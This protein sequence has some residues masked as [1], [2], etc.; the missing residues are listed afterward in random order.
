MPFPQVV[1]L[2]VGRCFLVVVLANVQ[3][4]ASLCVLL[5][6]QFGATTGRISLVAGVVLASL[7]AGVNQDCTAMMADYAR[8][9]LIV[10]DKAGAIAALSRV[11]V[12]MILCWHCA[13][14]V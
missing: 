5:L 3:P 2:R 11:C 9:V 6:E 8:S 1:G 12:R 4:S 13:L 10:M 14:L 7:V